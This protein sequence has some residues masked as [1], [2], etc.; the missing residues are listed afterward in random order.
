MFGMPYQLDQTPVMRIDI[1]GKTVGHG[2]RDTIKR[3]KRFCFRRQ[4]SAHGNC[5][6]IRVLDSSGCRQV[7][8]RVSSEKRCMGEWEEKWQNILG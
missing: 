4:L 5:L 1:S 8:G 6:T 2:F 3:I 7:P